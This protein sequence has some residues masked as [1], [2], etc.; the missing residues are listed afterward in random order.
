MILR[1][2]LSLA[3]FGALFFISSLRAAD[4]PD[5]RVKDLDEDIT[6][7]LDKAAALEKTK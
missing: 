7:N 4:V 1:H 2:W 3:G 5:R 6:D